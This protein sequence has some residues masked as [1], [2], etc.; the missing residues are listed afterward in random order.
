MAETNTK[1]ARKRGRQPD[2]SSKSGQIRA[3]LSTGMSVADIAKKVGC[4]P[5]LAYN[6]K[7]RMSKGPGRGPGRPP[8]SAKPAANLQNLDGLASIIQAVKGSEQQRA[9]MRTALERIQ[10][11]I[12]DAL[13]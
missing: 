8:K 5:A 2:A 4:T 1:S 9:Q 11:I 10:A 3:L 6:V 13:A 7:A 12:A